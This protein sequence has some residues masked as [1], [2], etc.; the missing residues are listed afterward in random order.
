MLQYLKMS[1]ALVI[2]MVMFGAFNT[3]VR[4]AQLITCSQSSYPVDPILAQ[5][6]SE[7]NSEPFNKP[8]IGNLFMFMGE[9]L[10]LFIVRQQESQR[11]IL[12][13]LN[14]GAPHGMPIPAKFFA[15]P[16]LLDVIGSGLSGIGMLYLSASVWQMMR[17]SL[18]IYTAILSVTFLNRKLSRQHI[19][20]LI[21]SATGLGLVGVSSYL[22]DDSSHGEHSLVFVGIGLTVLSQL[23][24]AVQVVL[25]ELLMK[26]HSLMYTQPR[27]ARVVAFEGVWGSCIM[28]VLLIGFQVLPGTD[29]G[30]FEN[31]LDSGEKMFNSPFLL[32]LIIAY[33]L[34]IAVFNV[35]G[36]TVSK[37]LSSVHR[38][39]IDSSRAAVVWIVQLTMGNAYG[40]EWT[41]H[42][43]IQAIGFIVLVTG[44]VVYNKVHVEENSDEQ[45]LLST[46][47]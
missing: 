4:K 16:A 42:S 23:C 7:P 46:S 9:V 36:M 31:S 40:T 2:G 47:I 19:L 33:L 41:R 32:T 44:T 20:G 11:R 8:W 21:L 45:V 14:G 18:V 10:L 1:K 13:N 26:G 15:L 17:G 24:T 34:S 12:E 43:W 37:R 22:D 6:C 28:I 3:I 25:E 27:P 38:T 35:L 39:L 29:H 5:D 30:S